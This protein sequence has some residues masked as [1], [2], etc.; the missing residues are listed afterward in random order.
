MIGAPAINHLLAPQTIA[1]A[2]AG[3]ISTELN[4]DTQL[5]H[6]DSIR[7]SIHQAMRFLRNPVIGCNSP[8]SRLFVVESSLDLIDQSFMSFNL[9]LLR[10]S[11]AVI[12][13]W[14][15]E[16]RCANCFI[17]D[18]WCALRF[19]VLIRHCKCKLLEAYLVVKKKYPSCERQTWQ[20]LI[21]L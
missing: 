9:L 10:G 15:F 6:S 12:Y 1:P 20:D 3:W 7:V 2:V 16:A 17:I 18:R 8:V 5:R 21:C 14:F 13:R 11:T 4:T 19:T